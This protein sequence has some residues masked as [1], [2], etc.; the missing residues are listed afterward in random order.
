M[1]TD[2]NIEYMGRLDDQVKIRGHRIELG[3]V[4]RAMSMHP[5]VKQAVVVAREYGERGKRLVGYVVGEGIRNREMREYLKERLPEYMV[6][7]AVVV[8]ERMP[9]TANGKLD[10]KRLPDAEMEQ[11]RSEFVLP[12]T[13][14]EQALAAIWSEILTVERIDVHDNFFE[15]GGHS[16]LAT[17]AI[18]RI[19]GQL[20]VDL[21]FRA[22]FDNPTIAG[23][24]AVIER[25]K[26][27]QPVESA[28]DGH[29]AYARSEDHLQASACPR[30]PIEDKLA[31]LW[32]EILGPEQTAV[33]GLFKMNSNHA[34][35]SK[36]RSDILKAYD[37][38]LPF[39]YFRGSPTIAGL[40]DAIEQALLVSA[41]EIEVARVLEDMGELSDEEVRALLAGEA[42][43]SQGG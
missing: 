13:P 5:E 6:P 7:W 20:D 31:K 23:L 34:L 24:A 21:S 10:R 15:L 42:Q 4:E 18:S 11:S 30:S 9:V 28:T 33:Q 29:G 16:L 39:S 2:W 22:Y 26:Q 41:G 37:V 14:V 40:A 32:K 12:G 1:M 38:E 43:P 35:A 27:A 25:M 19:R 17:Q 3:E 36:F 8:M